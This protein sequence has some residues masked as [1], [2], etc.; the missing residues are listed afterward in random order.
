MASLKC[1]RC[2]FHRDISGSEFYKSK[3]LFLQFFHQKS[4]FSIRIF[5]T[6]FFRNLSMMRFSPTEK[7]SVRF[8]AKNTASLSEYHPKMIPVP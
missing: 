3:Y 4:P 2:R 5:G 1:I 7:I 8:F 6:I